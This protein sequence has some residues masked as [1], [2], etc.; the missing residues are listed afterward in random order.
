MIKNRKRHKKL[1]VSASDP[2]SI[3]APHQPVDGI[4]S[5]SFK[6]I[7]LGHP[8]FDILGEPAEWFHQLF[9]RLKDFSHNKAIELL[10]NRSS[11][12]RCHPI[13]WE[14][15]TEPEGFSHLNDQLRG[16]CPYQ[17]S[18]SKERGRIHGM[19]I[20]SIFHVVWFDPNHNL[21]P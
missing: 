19:F 7:D 11:S 2:P 3:P 14:D 21:Y 16:V 10:A 17:L 1:G 9:I 4:L 18:V 13:N 12:I 15:T 20:D 6:L 8:Q 5:F